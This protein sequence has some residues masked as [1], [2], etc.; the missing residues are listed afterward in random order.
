MKQTYDFVA[1]TSLSVTPPKRINSK[2][3]GIAT[4]TPRRLLGQQ[5]WHCYGGEAEW[6]ECGHVR[7]AL[8]AVCEANEVAL[9]GQAEVPKHRTRERRHA[10]A[11]VG[12]TADGAQR[13]RTDIVPGHVRKVVFGRVA[14]GRS[15]VVA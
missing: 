8:C 12:C 6:R 10:A 1:S 14:G 13:R 11:T 9:G 3:M 5:R 15:A 2:C 7:P 4:G